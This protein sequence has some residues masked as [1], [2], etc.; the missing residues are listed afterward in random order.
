MDDLN[1]YLLS[2]KPRQ[3]QTA[4]LNLIQQNYEIYLPYHQVRKRKKTG[5]TLVTEPLFPRYLFIR[6]SHTQSN[7]APIRSTRG[8]ANI[9][10]FG[11][12]NA[13]VPNVLVSKLKTQEKH[14]FE[15][16]ANALTQPKFKKGEKVRILE[17]VMAGYDGIFQT[18][19]SENRVHILLDIANKYT[20]V[21]LPVDYIVKEA[22]G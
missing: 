17:G 7:W 5:H 4:K 12:A 1:W 14:H 19:S 11:N 20:R 18:E 10:R 8:V 22:Q 6:L 2:S 13:K 15:Q 3:E 16:N 21:K 9:I